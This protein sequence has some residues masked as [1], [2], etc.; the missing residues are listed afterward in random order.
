M[1]P[2]AK[3]PLFMTQMTHS[4]GK[5]GS[6]R[7]SLCPL[8]GPKQ[9]FYSTTCC[10]ERF[11]VTQCGSLLRVSM[12]VCV[13]VCVCVCSASSSSGM[14]PFFSPS[15]Y[16]TPLFHLSQLISSRTPTRQQGSDTKQNQ[17][18]QVLLKMTFETPNVHM[19]FIN[20]SLSVAHTQCC[21]QCR[22]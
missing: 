4:H 5:L 11:V 6:R 7:E 20:T 14:F 8:V 18:L 9:Q 19:N 17:T 15:I 2:S 1:K 21:P 10:N 3:Q 13:C 12:C 16:I 22:N